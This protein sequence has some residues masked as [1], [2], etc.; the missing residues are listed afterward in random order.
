M[1]NEFKSYL[2]RERKNLTTI[3]SYTKTVEEYVTWYETVHSVS[4]NCLRKKDIIEFKN[5]LRIYKG[6]KEE[7]IK[8]KLSAI[9]KFNEFLVR[10]SL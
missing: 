5:Y 7:S 6:Y 4:F 8:A 9:I 2:K 1:I 10:I 3:A